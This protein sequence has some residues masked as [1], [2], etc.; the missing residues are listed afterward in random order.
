MASLS[1][2][3]G[4]LLAVSVVTILA[5]ILVSGSIALADIALL[6]VASVLVIITVSPFVGSPWRACDIFKCGPF[7]AIYTGPFSSE[8]AFAIYACV[9]LIFLIEIRSKRMALIYLLPLLLVLYATESRTSQIAL[10][11]A[12]LIA[13]IILFG[14]KRRMPSV[15][16]LRKVNSKMSSGYVVVFGAIIP[17]IIVLGYYLILHAQPSSF[18]NRGGIWLRE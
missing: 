16:S 13:S 1:Q 9:A 11:C 3:I 5:I 12:A 8:N 10:G 18:S 6:T 17:I 4:R 2:S 7:G 14:K 15:S